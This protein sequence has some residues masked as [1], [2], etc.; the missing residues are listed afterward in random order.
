MATLL[1]DVGLGSTLF[2]GELK[3]DAVNFARV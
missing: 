2:V 1:A 3:L